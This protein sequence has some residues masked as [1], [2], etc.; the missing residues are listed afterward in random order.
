VVREAERMGGDP[1]EVAAAGRKESKKRDPPMVMH[2]F[3]FHS[4]PGLL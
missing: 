4:R 1:G 2:Q 3:P